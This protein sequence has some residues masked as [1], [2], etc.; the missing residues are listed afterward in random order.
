[1]PSMAAAA[2][3]NRLGEAPVLAGMLVDVGVAVTVWMGWAG[4]A[5]A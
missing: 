3:N 5:A 2:I 1:M 4:A